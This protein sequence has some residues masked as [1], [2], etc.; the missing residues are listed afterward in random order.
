MS[1]EVVMDKKYN[2]NEEE[3]QFQEV[4]SGTH[5]ANAPTDT[6]TATAIFERIKRQHIVLGLVFILLV[7]GAYQ[8]LSHVFHMVVAKEQVIA[9]IQKP[10]PKPLVKSEVEV[11]GETVNRLDHLAQ[12][13]SNVQAAIQSLNTQITDIQTSLVNLNT[14]LTQV[15]DEIQSL[16]SDQEILIQKQTKPVVKTLEKKKEIP[17]PI[18]YVRAVIPGR[19]WLATQ[20]GSTL[21]LGVGDTLAGYGIID[22]I[23]SEQG[24]V[25]LS[26]GAIIGY[27]P[28]DR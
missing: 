13:Q 6:D 3:Y 22:A 20:D 1:Y 15:N 24:T 18:Y 19:V 11:Q 10:T 5:F 25:T 4:E 7:I 23:N 12:G 27:S 26:S 28:D 16:H 14:Q 8:L 9:K 21:T 17:K 2:V